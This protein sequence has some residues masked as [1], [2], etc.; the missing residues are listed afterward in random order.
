MQELGLTTRN[1]LTL[2][3]IFTVNGKRAEENDEL[4]VKKIDFEAIVVEKPDTDI[5]E[6]ALLLQG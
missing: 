5:L 1:L 6:N 4:N 2:N 3:L